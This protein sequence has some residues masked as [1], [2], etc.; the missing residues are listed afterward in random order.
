MAQGQGGD[1][2]LDMG[3]VIIGGHSRGTIASWHLAQSGDPGILGIYYGDAAGNLDDVNALD[4]KV[5]AS[6][7]LSAWPTPKI[8][9]L[10][11]ASTTP[12]KA[13]RSST[14]IEQRDSAKLILG[15]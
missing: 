8:K 4:D 14:C 12:M 11:T 5:T 2:H 7:L 1:Y 15:S 3:K 13:K 6:S 10:T 9:R